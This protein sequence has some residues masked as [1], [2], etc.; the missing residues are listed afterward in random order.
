MDFRIYKSTDSQVAGGLKTVNDIDLST[1][2]LILIDGSK[3]IAQHLS[4]RLQFFLGEWFLDTTQGI[5][6]FQE[7][8]TKDFDLE[9]VQLIF[10]DTIT[11]TPGVQSLEEFNLQL[12]NANRVLRVNFK[13]QLTDSDD[14]LVYDEEL[15][16]NL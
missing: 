2:D 7:I 16:I 3:A 1:N 5:P 6:Y 13:A 9:T 14:P 8:L 11:T 10:S 4:I 12:N 15:V